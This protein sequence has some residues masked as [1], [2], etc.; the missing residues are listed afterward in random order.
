MNLP[1]SNESIKLSRKV[2][3][4]LYDAIFN[5]NIDKFIAIYNEY[6]TNPKIYN[7]FCFNDIK[8]SKINYYSLCSCKNKNL[9]KMDR[10]RYESLCNCENGKRY[11]ALLECYKNA[12][13]SEYPYLNTIKDI[14]RTRQYSYTFRKTK[15]IKYLL[16]TGDIDIEY[17]DTIQDNLT[18]KK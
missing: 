17:Q 8:L 9:V 2:V 12:C 15:C 3:T 14:M 16:E 7:T 5:D 11:L 4:E 18:N 6:S 13:S 1:I 10:D